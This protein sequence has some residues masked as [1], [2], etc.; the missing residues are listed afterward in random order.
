M[1]GSH[2]PLVE[3]ANGDAVSTHPPGR[4]CKWKVDVVGFV[5]AANTPYQARVLQNNTRSTITSA[6]SWD[7]IALDPARK[8]VQVGMHRATMP[9]SHPSPYGD[10]IFLLERTDDDGSQ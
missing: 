1:P 9:H 4:S 8:F 3:A 5:L 10:G 6:R 7:G 2:I